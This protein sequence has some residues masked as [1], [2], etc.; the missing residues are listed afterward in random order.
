MQ[1]IVVV[2]DGAGDDVP[3]MSIPHPLL[4]CRSLLL[5][6]LWPESHACSSTDHRSPRKLDDM[7]IKTSEVYLGYWPCQPTRLLALPTYR[8]SGYNEVP[9]KVERTHTQYVART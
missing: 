7:I 8:E 9:M 2:V 5:V 6:Q 3:A 4:F 1:T